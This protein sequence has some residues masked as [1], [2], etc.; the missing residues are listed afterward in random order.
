MFTAAAELY[1]AIYFTFKDYASEAADIAQ[2]IRFHHPSAV[3]VLDVGCGTGEH[4]RLLTTQHRF[5][6]DGVDLNSEFL[7]LAQ[8]KNP[9]SRF[10]TADMTDFDLAAR[11][12]AVICLFSSIGYVKTL[13]QLERALR[14]FAR[15]VTPRGVVIVEPWFPPGVL[16]DGHHS[17]RV[18]ESGTLRVTRDASTV[19]EGR[20]SRLRFDYTIEDRGDTRHIT[21]LHELGLFTPEETLQAF[22]AAGFHAEHEAPS[23][24]N[25]GFY[26]AR[27]RA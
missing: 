7:R 20:I 12:D 9:A 17:T 19:L 16:E 23:P 27:L 21:E 11:Y 22:A 1:D 2:R 15:H 13:P 4:A 14:C 18:A 25:R 26:A 24:T 10:F 8:E 6:V 5:L 3:T